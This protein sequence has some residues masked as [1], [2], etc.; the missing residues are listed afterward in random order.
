MESSNESGK[1]LH[2]FSFSIFAEK[3][4]KRYNIVNSDGDLEKMIEDRGG[5]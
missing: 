1:L 3:K 5:T 4:L 2:L